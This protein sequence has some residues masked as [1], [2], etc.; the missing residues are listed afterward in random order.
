[1]SD[2]VKVVLVLY[3]GFI[4]SFFVANILVGLIIKSVEYF[5]RSKIS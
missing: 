2:S 1:M 5:R 4:L 3:A